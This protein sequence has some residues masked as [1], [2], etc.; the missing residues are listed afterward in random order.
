[1]PTSPQGEP[2]RQAALRLA[3]L[4]TRIVNTSNTVNQALHSQYMRLAALDRRIKENTAEGKNHEEILEL[5]KMRVHQL[6]QIQQVIQSKLNVLIEDEVQHRAE[7]EEALHNQGWSLYTDDTIWAEDV[8]S[9]RTIEQERD[10]LDGRPVVFDGTTYGITVSPKSGFKCSICLEE[11]VQ[12]LKCGHQFHSE[13]IGGYCKTFVD[14][15]K[16]PRYPLCRAKL[17]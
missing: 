4:H 14:T 13:C 5:R 15:A 2:A 7:L 9:D 10:A 11:V 16:S 3:S 6:D 1:M 17:T 8:D 12:I